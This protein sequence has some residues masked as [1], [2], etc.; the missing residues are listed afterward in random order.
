MA[1]YRQV[2]TTIWQDNWVSELEPTEKLLWMYLLTNAK[3]TQSGVYE[4]SPRY[5][6]FETGLSRKE[7][8]E[9]LQHFIK[10]GRV[11]YDQSTNEIMIENWLKY[12]SA[13]SPK[14]AKVIDKEIESIKSHEFENQVIRMALHY[15]YPIRAKVNDENTL[16]GK[17]NTVSIGYPYSS[18]TISQP[19][20][21]P[22]QNHNQNQHQNDS[23]QGTPDDAADPYAIYQECFGALNSVNSQNITEWVK[24]F[25]SPELVIEAMRRAATNNKQ[26]SYAEG[27]MKNWIKHNVKTMAQVDVQD[28]EHMRKQ[29]SHPS[30]KAQ[31]RET[32]PEWAKDGYQHETKPVDEATKD[33]LKAQMARLKQEQTQEA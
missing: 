14:V 29:S 6:C 15:E 13:R 11:R 8:N 10:A 3:T 9:A 26:Y 7:V 25:G 24:D 16:S 28:A 23:A 20:P 32:L 1:I 22:S 33:A 4:F 30:S 5:T 17:E 31:S 18:D 27:I 21:E 2:H 12:N 19:E